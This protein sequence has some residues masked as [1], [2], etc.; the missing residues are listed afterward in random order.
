MWA[1]GTLNGKALAAPKFRRNMNNSILFTMALAGLLSCGRAGEQASGSMAPASVPAAAIPAHNISSQ[2]TY[3]DPDGGRVT[4]QN[5]YPKGG[6][7]YTDPAG[8]ACGYAVFWTRVLNASAHPLTLT[9]DMPARAYPLSNFPGA[10]LAVLVPADTMTADELPLPSYGLTDIPAFLDAYHQR[11]TAFTRTI[12]PQEASGLYFVLRFS[13]AE[14]T[15]MT[16]TALRLHDQ[17]LVYHLAR[18]SVTKP[19]TLIE[20][21]DFPCGRIDLPGLDLLR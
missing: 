16:R 3:A 4:I 6:L 10:S 21:V 20:E 8:H 9:L 19:I 7:T 12:P 17:D 2:S 11:G 14:A 1:D 18:Y 5:G 15:G 13:T